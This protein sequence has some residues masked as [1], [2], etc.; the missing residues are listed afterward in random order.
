VQ[1]G[2][3]AISAKGIRKSAVSVQYPHAPA[4]QHYWQDGPE[5]SGWGTPLAKYTN[6]TPAVVQGQYG[7]GVVILAGIH[8]EAPDDWREGMVFNTSTKDDNAYAVTL[9]KAAL[10]GNT[11]AHF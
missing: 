7:K 5:L 10:N 11:L 9:I 4:M 6:N 3:Y 1:F 2:F 8:A